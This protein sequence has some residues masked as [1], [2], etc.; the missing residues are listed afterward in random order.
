VRVVHRT[1]LS[2]IV[3]LVVGLAAIAQAAN[4]TVVP[5]A[6]ASGPAADGAMKEAAVS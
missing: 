6:A 4:T 3:V 2:A 5:R 1:A